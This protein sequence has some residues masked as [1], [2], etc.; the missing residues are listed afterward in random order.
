MWGETYVDAILTDHITV[1]RLPKILFFSAEVD[2]AAYHKHPHRSERDWLF[3]VGVGLLYLMILGLI[4]LAAFF[5]SQ[6]LQYTG[7]R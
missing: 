5:T 4:T 7:W 6:F 2:M 3:A 1:L